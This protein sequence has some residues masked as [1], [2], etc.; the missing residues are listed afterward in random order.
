M[1]R[2]EGL[3]LEW[4][5]GDHVIKG[6]WESLVWEFGS[7]LE[8]RMA[9]RDG[10]QL[11]LL[12]RKGPVWVHALGRSYQQPVCGRNIEV[13]NREIGLEAMAIVLIRE[14]EG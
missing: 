7:D 4:Q 1:E 3:R 6:L 5:F 2:G 9:T 13:Q 12:N 11:K 10:N 14:D 8:R